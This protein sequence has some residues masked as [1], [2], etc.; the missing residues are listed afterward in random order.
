MLKWSRS[1]HFLWLPSP[2]AHKDWRDYAKAY[3]KRF[4]SPEPLIEEQPPVKGQRTIVVIPCCNEPD[5]IGTL[6]SLTQGEEAWAE[7]IVV[8]NHSENAPEPVKAQ[9]QRTIEEFQKWNKSFTKKWEALYKVSRP[10][11]AFLIE[12]LDLPAKHAGVGLARKIGMDEALRRFVKQNQCGTI[13]CLDA[14]CRVSLN[15][16]AHLS[17]FSGPLGHVSYEHRWQDEAD[18]ELRSGI[19]HYELFLRYYVEGLRQAGF[20]HAIPT[21]GSCMVVRA[22]VYAKYQGMN[23]RKAGEDFYFLH[24]I[25]PHERLAH[26]TDAMVFP[27]CR[28][29]DRVPFGTG[30]AQ[31]DWLNQ[32]GGDYLTYDPVIFEELSQLLKKVGDFYI[33]TPEDVAMGLSQANKQFVSELKCLEKIRLIRA[34]TRDLDQFKKQF[35]IWF[36]GFMCMKYVHFLRDQFYPNKPITEVAGPLIKA[37]S[38]DAA[39]LLERYR[40]IER[41]VEA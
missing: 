24:R 19:I 9:N 31:Q 5:L 7:I 32:G 33:G 16:L 18:P 15:Y 13:V 6:N 39:A 30:K 17:Q 41:P 12:A 3:F 37:N 1:I 40:L 36:D 14:D 38:T 11:Q 29:S 26:I 8:I 4:A 10:T 23:R 20:P 22:D 35:F 28:T 25:A 21:V 2:M 34:N 27:S